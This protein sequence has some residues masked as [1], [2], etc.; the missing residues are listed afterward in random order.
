MFPSLPARRS[1]RHV[2]SVRLERP[3]LKESVNDGSTPAH[4]QTGQHLAGKVHLVAKK[5]T[6]LPYRSVP[7]PP[8]V[9][10]T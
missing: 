1:R 4:A 10:F 9:I 6:P 5:N 2:K 8:V 3:N 7:P